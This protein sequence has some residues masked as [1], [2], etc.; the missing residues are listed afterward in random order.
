MS[1]YIK[2]FKTHQE[3]I[4]YL[5]DS[6]MEYPFVGVCDECLNYFPTATIYVKNNHIIFTSDGK[7]TGYLYEIDN[8]NNII[9]GYQIGHDMTPKASGNATYYND[10]YRTYVPYNPD[11]Y[12]AWNIVELWGT[13]EGPGSNLDDMYIAEIKY[14][15]GEYTFAK[16]HKTGETLDNTWIEQYASYS[17]YDINGYPG[18][19]TGPTIESTWYYWM[20][21]ATQDGPY[22]TGN[23]TVLNNEDTIYFPI[24]RAY[25]L[26]PGAIIDIYTQTAAV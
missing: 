24:K 12:Y 11:S 22:T 4:N 25:K 21:G 16:Y 5:T 17:P 26:L 19:Y 10:G 3:H 6:S 8:N 14:Y 20:S 9:N 18:D 13:E 1:K 15:Y 7:A 2:R 23:G